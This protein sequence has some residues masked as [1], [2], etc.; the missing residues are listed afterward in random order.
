MHDKVTN[1]MR[2]YLISYPS[3]SASYKHPAEIAVNSF[4]GFLSS[5]DCI[6]R[7][8]ITTLRP[9]LEIPSCRTRSLEDAARYVQSHPKSV[10]MAY[11]PEH[12][13]NIATFG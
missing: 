4:E 8:H 3:S 12:I 1:L 7:R 11:F 10:G 2:Y 9:S 13:L 6:V 5:I